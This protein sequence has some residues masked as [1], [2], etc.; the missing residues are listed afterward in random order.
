M[1]PL[2]VVPSNATA[3]IFSPSSFPLLSLFFPG[4]FIVDFP[5]RRCRFSVEFNASFPRN[6]LRSD[7]RLART[8][9]EIVDARNGREWS[10]FPEPLLNFPRVAEL[11]V[12]HFVHFP[13]EKRKGTYALEVYFRLDVRKSTDLPCL[14][15]NRDLGEGHIRSFDR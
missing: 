2:L 11:I 6:T 7:A 15:R 1:Y 4:I 10:A 3:G 13:T 12:P 5:S 9:L 8:D 14:D